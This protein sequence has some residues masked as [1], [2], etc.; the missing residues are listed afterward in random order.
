MDRV[1]GGRRWVGHGGSAPGMNGELV[2]EPNGGYVV[3]VL[4]NFDP[5][6]AGQV[7]NFILGRLPTPTP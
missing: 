7:L 1:V 2:F 4:S 6:A 5:P 3:V